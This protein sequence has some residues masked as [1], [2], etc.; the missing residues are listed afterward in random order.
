M[1]K[2]Q[3]GSLDGP[4]PLV[5]TEAVALPLSVAQVELA[6]R[7][8][9]PYSFGQ[10]PGAK[11]VMED[12]GS[13]RL[14]GYARFNFRSAQLG[15]RQQ[16]LGVITYKISIQAEN[17]QCRIRVSHF[18]HTGNK[19]AVGGPIDLG[20]IYAGARPKERVPGISLGTAERLHE[21]MRTQVTARVREVV[22]NF[23][24]RMRQTVEQR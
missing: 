18:S 19:N 6:A 20:T 2:P 15:S 14:E 5:I 4:R 3:E 1:A 22:K 24:S 12:M 9:W 10:E 7:N 8:A 13:G 17:G 16:T 21:D 11:M 23:S